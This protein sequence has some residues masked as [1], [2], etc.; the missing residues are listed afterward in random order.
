MTT[1]TDESM[2]SM[3]SI[4]SIESIRSPALIEFDKCSALTQDG[5][6]RWL[7]RAQNFQVELIDAQAG[8]KP[9][10]WSCDGETL[11]LLPDTGAVVTCGL[12]KLTAMARSICIVPAGACS[13]APA[14]AGKIVIL[15]SKR[16]AL[17]ARRALNETDYAQLGYP[18]CAERRAVSTPT[19]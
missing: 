14:G 15:S 8:A 16:T 1:M 7:A 10:K 4:A 6:R 18:H 19:R 9:V 2:A 17:A 13:V 11:L 5:A 12:M 3:T